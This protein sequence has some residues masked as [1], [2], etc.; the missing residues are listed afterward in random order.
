MKLN[1][2]CVFD[3]AV[4]AYMRPFFMHSDG[5]AVRFFSDLAVDAEHE[6][7]KHPQDY[8]LARVG[9]W[10]DQNGQTAT[11]AVSILITGLE[12]V[13]ASRKVNARQIDALEQESKEIE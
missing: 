7:A 4:G 10:D 6:V 11:E 13:A 2:Y 8:S 12:A 9:V 5:Q 1:M 3:V